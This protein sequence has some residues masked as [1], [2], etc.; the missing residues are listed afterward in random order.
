MDEDGMGCMTG[1]DCMKP[2]RPQ[3][4]TEPGRVKP[5]NCMKVESV[6]P[7]EDRSDEDLMKVEQRRVL[8]LKNQ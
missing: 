7:H 6:V 4:A 1:A 3:E 5:E 2:R 8:N